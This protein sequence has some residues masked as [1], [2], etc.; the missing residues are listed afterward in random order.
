MTNEDD[1]ESEKESILTGKEMSRYE[2]C[3]VEASLHARTDT[4]VS[5]P[6][7]DGIDVDMRT[8]DD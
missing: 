3:E 1:A 4:I 5:Q 7:P 2:K 6:P 8:G